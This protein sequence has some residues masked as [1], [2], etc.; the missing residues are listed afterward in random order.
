[1]REQTHKQKKGVGLCP[2]FI[3]SFSASSGFTLYFANLHERGCL[4]LQLVVSLLPLRVGVR[5]RSSLLFKG[6]RGRR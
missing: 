1:V 6:Q 2:V 3:Q 4:W 5:G